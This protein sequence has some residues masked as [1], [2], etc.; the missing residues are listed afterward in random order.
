MEK[1]KRRDPNMALIRVYQKI[2]NDVWKVTFVNDP[3]QLSEADKN[4]MRKLGEPEV[5]VGGV[6]PGE[7]DDSFTLDDKYIKIKSG[8]PYTAE[9]DSKDAPFDTN[10]Q[11]KVENYREE[12]ISRISTAFDDLRTFSDTFSGEKTYNI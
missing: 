11:Q 2:E 1:V 10:T 7:G 9:F 5:N 12:I 8:L 4:L 6:I 3:E